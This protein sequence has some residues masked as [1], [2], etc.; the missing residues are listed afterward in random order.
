MGHRSLKY[1]YKDMFYKNEIMNYS[2]GDGF[3]SSRLEL[4]LREDKGFTYGIGSR[5]IGDNIAGNFLIFSNVRT[6]ATDS[7]LRE[8]LFEMENYLNKGITPVELNFV[9][10]TMLNSKLMGYE[11]T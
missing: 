7:A 6:S 11:T 4:N 2:L 1:S 10:Q 9:K 8:I 5:F 3:I